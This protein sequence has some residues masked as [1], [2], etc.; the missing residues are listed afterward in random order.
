VGTQVY[1]ISSANAT[2]P[3]A[4]QVG[5]QVQVLYAR[6]N[7]SLGRINSFFELW[8]I[9]AV[10]AGA[11]ILMAILVNGFLFIRRQQRQ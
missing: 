7:P 10:L 5:Q 2:D 9:P 8:A 1:R 6:D 3:P 11:G 4:Y